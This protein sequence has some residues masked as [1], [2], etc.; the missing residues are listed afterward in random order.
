MHTVQVEVRQVDQSA[1][2]LAEFLGCM[3]CQ[4]GAGACMR[5]TGVRKKYH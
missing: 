4:S 5:S 2:A 1:K 3:E